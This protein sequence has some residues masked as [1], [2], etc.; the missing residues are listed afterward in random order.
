MVVFLFRLHVFSTHTNAGNPGWSAFYGPRI[1]DSDV[2]ATA[3]A[4]FF[5]GTQ[6][7][8]AENLQNEI[9]KQESA[10]EEALNAALQDIQDQVERHQGGSQ[11]T[12]RPLPDSRYCMQE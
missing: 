1:W 3:V 2:A 4:A 11:H 10:F 8:A 6:E 12:P 9:A 5:P 7:A